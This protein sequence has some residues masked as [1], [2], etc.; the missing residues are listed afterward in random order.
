MKF[1]VF[2]KKH[3]YIIG[4]TLLFIAAIVLNEL[5]PGH[6]AAIIVMSV[7]TVLAGFHIFKK[8][9]DGPTLQDGRNRLTR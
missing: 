7:L 3:V 1:L 6:L 5:I 8:G 9:G 2:I 4:L